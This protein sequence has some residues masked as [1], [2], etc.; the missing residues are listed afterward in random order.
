MFCYISGSSKNK[1]ECPDDDYAVM[2]DRVKGLLKITFTFE[3]VFVFTCF[4][5]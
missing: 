2:N 5:L 3:S 1:N 4:W